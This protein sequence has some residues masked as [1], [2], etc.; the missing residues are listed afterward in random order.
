MIFKK[1]FSV[2]NMYFQFLRLFT[3]KNIIIKYSL[4]YIRRSDRGEFIE[5]ALAYLVF[6]I[7]I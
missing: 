3:K 7:S 1:L 5:I 2:L 6:R 4:N